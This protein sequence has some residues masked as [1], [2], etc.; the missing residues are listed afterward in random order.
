M[1]KSNQHEHPLVANIDGNC[2][3][4]I[5]VDAHNSILNGDPQSFG[6]LS[7]RYDIQTARAFVT[8]S[9]TTRIIRDG[10]ELNFNAN[11]YMSRRNGVAKG[12]DIFNSHYAEFGKGMTAEEFA[13]IFYDDFKILGG[14]VTKAE[15][16]DDGPDE[17]TS[18]ASDKKGKGKNKK[19]SQRVVKDAYIQFDRINPTIHKTELIE[20]QGTSVFA[21]REDKEMGAMPKT[22]CIRYGVFANSWHADRNVAIARNVTNEDIEIAMFNHWVGTARTRSATRSDIMPQLNVWIEFNDLH[23]CMDTRLR[24]L[25]RVNIINDDIEE[26]QIEGKNDYTL[27]CSLFH[28]FVDEQIKKGFLKKVHFFGNP[29]FLA[30]FFDDKNYQKNKSVYAQMDFDAINKRA[31]ETRQNPQDMMLKIAK[32]VSKIKSEGSTSSPK[33]KNNVSNPKTEKSA[34]KKSKGQ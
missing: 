10:A 18:E 19:S 30:D 24:E 14:M 16:G 3:G 20:H 13:M 9:S 22:R 32:S 23:Y 5:L 4:I 6:G 29:P 28:A 25:F 1:K 7:Q 8:R 17:E 31:F 21:T 26:Y 2:H 27:D 33:T 11:N 15:N 34:P 12:A